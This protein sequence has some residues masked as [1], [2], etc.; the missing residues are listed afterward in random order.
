MSPKSKR[1]RAALTALVVA[2]G[3]LATTGAVQA[4]RT[5]PG[6][7]QQHRRPGL[8]ERTATYP[9]F[10]NRPAG[11]DPAAGTVAEISSVSEDGRTLVHTDAVA[12]RIGFLDITDPGRPRG[13]GTLSLARLGDA[14][15]EP[16]SVTVVGEYV[17]VVV[18]TSASHARPSGRLDVVSLHDRERVA[19]W[20]ADDHHA[21]QLLVD[22]LR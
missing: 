7:Q 3:T 18:N 19:I 4:E 11:D 5:H 13:L 10:Q 15:D 9:V 21:Y 12:R 16:T 22:A 8:F 17:L 1:T 14:E 2:A 20:E 6:Q